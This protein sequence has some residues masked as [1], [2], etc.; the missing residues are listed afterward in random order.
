MKDGVRFKVNEAGD[1]E[2]GCA[3]V[4]QGG[5]LQT[6]SGEW[7]AVSMLDFV[8]VGRTVCLV[9]VTWHEGWPMFG[10]EGNLGRTPRTWFKPNTG[11]EAAETPHAPYERCDDFNGKKLQR[12]WQWNHEPIDSKWSLKNGRLRLNAMPA[13]NFLWA[14]NTL[15]QRCIGPVSS[16]T[17]TLYTKNLKDGDVAGLGLINLPYAWIGV[18]KD[19]NHKCLRFMQQSTGTVDADIQA[20]DKIYLR[21]TGDYDE[22]WASFSYSVDGK[23]FTDIGDTLRLPYQL[24]TFQ[25]SRYSLF[26]FNKTQD[27]MLTASTKG[28]DKRMGGY[29]EFD[30]FIVEEPMADRSANL[31]TGKVIT[32]E[33]KANGTRIWGMKRG[34][35]HSAKKGSRE[36]DS[37]DCMFKVIDKGQGKVMLE[38]MNGMGYMTISGLGLSGDVR[39]VKEPTEASLF[40]WQDMLRGDC[41]LMS[42]KNHRFVGC[43]PDMGEPYSTQFAGA[44]PNRKNGCVFHFNVVE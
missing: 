35:C 30:D 9:P 19:G 24:K 17:V 36:Y 3:T 22:M 20:Y 1:N 33:N 15:T 41:M 14:R 28:T 39:L 31:P 18:C 2:L 40:M 25:G 29:A 21:I 5:M 44:D 34:L 6:P 26:C 32:L 37:K 23:S 7:W 4:H 10:L 16:A 11:N 43:S 42:L 38:C 27:N 8:A 13:E 12:V